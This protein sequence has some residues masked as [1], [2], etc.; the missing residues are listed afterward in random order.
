MVM[1]KGLKWLIFLSLFVYIVVRAVTVPITHDEAYSY[2]LVKT[3]YVV[4]MAGTANTHWINA[5]GMKIGSFLLGDLPWQLRIFSI[6]A[7]LIYG[8]SAIKISEKIQNKL[9]GLSLFIC[10]VANPFLLDFFSLARGYGLACAFTLASIWKALKLLEKNLWELKDWVPIVFFGSLAVFSNYTT[11]YFFMAL[12]CSF[13]SFAIYKRGGQHFL[14]IRFSKWLIIIVGTSIAAISNL[15]FIKLYTGDLEYGGNDGLIYSVFGSLVSGSLYVPNMTNDIIVF[16]YV[17]FLL[18][19]VAVAYSG[20]IF[21]VDKTI[22][23][24]SFLSSIVLWMLLFNISF[25]YA[26]DTPYLFSRTTLVFYPCIIL[27]FHFLINEIQ[28]AQLKNRFLLGAFSILLIAVFLYNFIANFNLYYC[29][30]WKDQAD[31]KRC[32]DVANADGAENILIQK[33]HAGVYINYYSVVK[34]KQYSFK[35]TPF[36]PEEIVELS[37]SFKKTFYEYDHAILLPPFNLQ[38]MHN[39]GLR[40]TVLEQ[41]HLTG[42]AVL[43]IQK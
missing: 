5:L 37:D 18:V 38:Q 40:F 8:F 30:E 10:L 14:P 28:F 11:F 6:L 34:S 21:L 29:Y 33:W 3:N 13:L 24:L 39:E 43:K 32:L 4:A 15:L 16:A 31:T 19:V 9:L 25:H 20:Y 7:W 2:F 23:P 35:I 12:V 17:V 42:A 1:L 27:L 41:F 22:T 36:L 26:F